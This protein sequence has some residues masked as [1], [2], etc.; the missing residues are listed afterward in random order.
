MKLHVLFEHGGDQRPHGCSHIRL[1]R[2]LGHP[3]NAGRI[4]W[5]A[6]TTYQGG[7]DVVLVER[8]WRPESVTVAAVEELI[9]R[10]RRDRARLLFTVDDNLLDLQ[11]W[12]AL[13]R[14]L[15]GELTSIVRLLA[16]EADGVIVSTEP[17]RERMRALNPR[18]AVVPNAVDERLFRL[19]EPR[20]ARPAGAPLTLGLMGTFS[21]EGDLMMILEP[22]RALLRARQGRVRLQIVGAVGDEG[23]LRVFDGL[24]VELVNSGRPVDYPAFVAWMVDSLRWD[25][26]IAP[27]EDSPFTRCKSDLKL[28]DYAALGLPGIYSRVLPYGATV[29]HLETGWLA[30]SSTD[31]WREALERLVD[32]ADL[33]RAIAANARQYVAAERTLARNAASWPDAVF[34]LAA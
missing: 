19:S 17:L 10:V 11:P 1:L 20:P 4:E 6:G 9:A 31:G 21:H 2:P 32:D 24:P 16:R 23:L 26:A 5:T 34:S 18:I 14:P 27:L 28:L 13:Q 3:V 29:R 30:E 8:M 7:A 33:R 22:L 12:S 25:L 15:G